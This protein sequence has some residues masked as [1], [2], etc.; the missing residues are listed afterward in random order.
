MAEHFP[1]LCWGQAGHVDAA[2]LLPGDPA[3]CL[4][5]PGA[6]LRRTVGPDDEHGPGRRMSHHRGEE[7]EDLLI[8]PVQVV[9][10]QQY[11]LS[12]RDRGDLRDQRPD[13]PEPGS[14]RIASDLGVIGLRV[15]AVGAQRIL[16]LGQ[17]PSR[18][19]AGDFRADAPRG[20]PAGTGQPS[21]QG[22]G[23]RGLAGA[24]HAGY[25]RQPWALRRG[26]TRRRS[27][28]CCQLRVPPDEHMLGRL[29]NCWRLRW[30]T[31]AR[32]RVRWQ[33]EMCCLG[34]D[35]GLQPA[36]IGPWIKTQFAE[37][38]LACPPERCQGIT[39]P[40]GPVQG[41]REQPPPLLPIGV[42]VDERFQIGHRIGRGPGRQQRFR[43]TADGDQP[44]FRQSGGFRPRPILV[45]E[46]RIGRSAPEP[47]QVVQQPSRRPGHAVGQ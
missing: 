13:A 23:E 25:Q 36:Q 1:H 34:E 35:V 3:E 27:L 41:Q 14:D 11:G 12:F 44:K 29:A 6:D 33:V 7:R 20:E 2:R 47:Q 22:P 39:L 32:Y 18:R 5:Q 21:G 40:T 28:E 30:S 10:H 45:G 24:C 43:P 4:R 16:Q 42:P 26:S 31:C 9:E 38:D 17:Q 8:R 37:Q 19:C 46:F 15:I